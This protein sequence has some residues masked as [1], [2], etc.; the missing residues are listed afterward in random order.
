MIS[1]LFIANRGEIALRIARAAADLGIPYVAAHPADDAASLHVRNAELAMQLPGRGASA[2]LDIDALVAA[3]VSSGCDA[4]HPGYGFLSENPAFARKVRESGL[5]FVGP[6]PQ[7]LELFGDKAAARQLARSCGIPMLDGTEG[8]TSLED[9]RRFFASLQPGEMA[10]IKAVAGG[11]GRGIRIVRSAEALDEAYEQCRSEALMSFGQ[12]GVYIERYL[13]RA[14]HIEVQIAGDGREIVHFGERECTVQ[15]RHQKVVEIAPSPTLRPEMRER[16]CQAAIA[17]GKAVSYE[18]L[19]TVEF[20]VSDDGARFAFT[21]VNPRLQVEHTVTEEVFGID[22]VATQI[23]LAEGRSLAELGFAPG[24]SL[25]PRGH[26]IQLRIN[27]ERLDSQGRTAPSSGTIKAYELPTGPGIRI[28][29]FGYAGYRTSTLYDSLLAKLIVHSPSSAYADAVRRAQRALKE[30]RVTGVGTN[31]PLLQALL[32]HPDFRSN[33]LHTTFLEERIGELVAAMPAAAEAPAKSHRSATAERRNLRDEVDPLALFSATSNGTA[34]AALVSAVADDHGYLQAAPLQGTIIKLA[35]EPGSAVAKGQ[36][37]AVMEA[38]KME[39]LVTA[40]VAG[41][42]RWLHVT[43][44]DTVFEGEPL[45]SIEEGEAGGADGPDEQSV[46]LDEIRGDLAQVLARQAMLMDA[47]RPDAVARRRKTG[48]RTVRE[49]IADLCDEGSFIEYGGLAIAAQSSRRSFEQ[50]LAMSP[51]DGMVTGLGTVNGKLFDDERARCAVMGYDY[52]VFAGTQGIMNHHKTDRILELADRWSMPVVLF[53][54]GGG[55]RPGD[56]WPSPAVLHTPTFRDF[57]ALSGKVPTIGIVSGRCFAGNAALLG[58]CNVIIATRNTTLGM[59]GPAMIE[60][61]GLGVFPPEVVG[62]M[63]V[64]VPNGVVDIPVEDEAEA[65]KAAKAYLSYF[66][67]PVSEWD[68]ADQRLLRHAVP[69]N[70]LRAYD[71]R[72]LI[73]TLADRDSVLE[74]RRGFGRAMV[75]ALTRIEGRPIG[76]IA[77]NSQHLGGAIDADAADKAARFI[78]LCDAFDI[79]VLAL[80]DTPGMMVGPEVEKTAHVRHCSRM[81]VAGARVKVPYFTVVLRKGYGLGA[82]AMAAGST[83][84]SVFTLAW[85]TAEF[86]AMGI[87]GSVKLGYRRELEAIADP[88]ERRAWFERKVAEEYE[89][90][91]ALNAA[92]MLEVDNV[93]DPA[94][95]RRW[96]VRG[97]KALPPRRGK[98]LGN[99]QLLDTW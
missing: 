43:E 77:N 90:N 97:L 30:F 74:L 39:H 70:R 10:I 79:P 26:A 34:V 21:E 67:G 14:R 60:G 76:I 73:A 75:T 84:A 3:A 53:A 15:R 83:H 72:A 81:F 58:A 17:L 13:S 12:D 50:L 29:G 6:R 80:C 2:Y 55:G 86:G 98:P 46:D 96:L 47:A 8:P 94:E 89:K 52:T 24:E 41:T 56:D 54:E 85:P 9:A 28:D 11:G 22:L 51:A 69:E 92:T 62:P 5:V 71:I 33:N 48:Q 23:R 68:C 87:E 40:E 20:L 91:K 25:A 63:S 65:V 42:V 18:G 31:I 4:V 19:G 38:M 49:N 59:G 45:L 7:V 16:L 82:L 61:G 64:Q 37:V 99:G 66:Q 36:T 78:Q 57:G 35:V 27:M 88:A 1:K 95:T 32:D 44:G 93:I